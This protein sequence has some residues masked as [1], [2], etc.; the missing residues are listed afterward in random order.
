M[1]VL[2]IEDDLSK[3]QPI[4]AALQA[5][6][7]EVTWILGIVRGSRESFETYTPDGGTDE[8]YLADFA[9]AF[10]DYKLKGFHD[11][12]TKLIRP[13]RSNKIFCIAISGAG[14]FNPKLM[15]AGA[16]HALPKEQV[17]DSLANGTLDLDA[18]V[19]SGK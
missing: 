4:V 14:E 7:H 5:K 10:V 2:L 9:V 8:I 15:Q 18:L 6:G 17:V 19:A 13:L 16:Q 3:G 1:K 11:E 12:G